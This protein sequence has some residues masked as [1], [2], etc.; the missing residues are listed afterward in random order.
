M[1][2]LFTEDELKNI[3]SAIPLEWSNKMRELGVNPWW[4]VWSYNEN[5]IGGAPVDMAAKFLERFNEMPYL[6]ANAELDRN[7]VQALYSAISLVH[8][9][10]GI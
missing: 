3:D 9:A 8:E 6:L 10:L 4:Y 1:K 2:L 5:R 7:E